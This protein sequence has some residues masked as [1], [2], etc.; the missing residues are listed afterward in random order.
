[1]RTRPYRPCT[2]GK[3]ERVIQTLLREWAYARPYRRSRD[4]TQAL[5]AWLIYYNRW[6]PHGSLAG[7]TPL[8]R[9]DATMNNVSG[10]YI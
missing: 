3:A 8:S 5:G 4:R 10:N 1:L 6:R 7:N 2:N 9:I